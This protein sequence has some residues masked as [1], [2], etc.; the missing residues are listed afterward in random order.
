MASNLP[1]E[2]WKLNTARDVAE[3]NRHYRRLCKLF[4]PDL[5]APDHR[6]RYERHMQLVNEAYSRALEKFNILTYRDPRHPNSSSRKVHSDVFGNAADAQAGGQDGAGE[7]ERSRPRKPGVAFAS[8][9]A[10]RALGRALAV[11]RDA[12][13][14]NSFKAV[15]DSAERQVYKKALPLLRDVVRR[16]SSLRE[17]RDALYYLIVCECNLRNFGFALHFI[18]QYRRK[19]GAG[20]RKALLHFYA[21]VCHHRM[22]NFAEAVAEY[23]QF[24][25]SNPRGMM[26]HFLSVVAQ[27]SLAAEDGRTPDGL[28]YA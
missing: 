25:S 27:H 13:T 3:L 12:R 23:E 14:F 17:G 15:T 16:F 21:G 26:K 1:Q 10:A 24:I 22:G 9:E 4:H 19:H 8:S 7:P 28:P 2:I 18:Q 20:E 5:Q 6:A 11:L